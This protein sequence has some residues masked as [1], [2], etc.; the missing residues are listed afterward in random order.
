[1]LGNLGSSLVQKINMQLNFKSYQVQK[2]VQI[3]KDYKFKAEIFV[4]LQIFMLVIIANAQYCIYA[5]PYL[6]LA[7]IQILNIALSH[8]RSDENIR[9]MSKVITVIL[10]V[11]LPLDLILHYVV[12]YIQESQRIDEDFNS[13]YYGTPN[14][15]KLQGYQG[16]MA[17]TPSYVTFGLK[18]ALFLLECTKYKYSYNMGPVYGKLKETYLSADSSALP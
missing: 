15:Y 10:L 4:C 8:G 14:E 17:T 2:C 16:I 5:A 18:I 3:I 13:R 11:Y 9:V 7:L 1:M 6:I 12:H